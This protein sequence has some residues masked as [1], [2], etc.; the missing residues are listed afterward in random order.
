MH[1]GCFASSIMVRCNTSG[2]LPSTQTAS[3]SPALVLASHLNIMAT[4]V[5]AIEHICVTA[6]HFIHQCFCSHTEGL[7][8]HWIAAFQSAGLA[9]HK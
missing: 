2:T 7:K 4:P 9:S 3:Q 6:A 5:S 8:T 1:W